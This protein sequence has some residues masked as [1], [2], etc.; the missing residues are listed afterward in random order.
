MNRAKIMAL[1]LVAVAAMGSATLSAQDDPAATSSSTS[2]PAVKEA[3]QDLWRTNIQSPESK[4]QPESQELMAAIRRLKSFRLPVKQ[5]PA[6]IATTA[7]TTRSVAPEPTSRSTDVVPKVAVTL[8]AKQ[9]AE[10]LKLKQ[11]DVVNPAVLAKAL[12]LSGRLPEA[13]KFYQM[14][15]ENE[16]DG[17]EK[18]WL[19]FQPAN[20]L[21]SS[22]PKAFGELLDKLIAEHSDSLWSDVA[23][24]QKELVTWLGAVNNESMAGKAQEQMSE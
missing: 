19:M 21:R 6:Q 13:A 18:A 5:E 23:R 2:Q 9:L 24:S 8:S 20:C 11:T 1:L 7:P 22:D 10:L 14:A 3:M 15:M 4:N 16:S 17:E 12:H